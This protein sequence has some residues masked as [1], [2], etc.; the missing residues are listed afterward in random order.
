MLFTSFSLVWLHRLKYHR[1]RERFCIMLLFSK[2]ICV[3]LNI[4]LFIYFVL[5]YDVILVR[6]THLFCKMAFGEK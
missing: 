1:F 5:V 2:V 3:P 6:F 4:L